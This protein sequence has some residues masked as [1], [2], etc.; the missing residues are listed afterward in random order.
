[1]DIP[2]YWRLKS[3]RYRLEG[4]RCQD[5]GNLSFPPRLVCQKCKSR[6]SEPFEFKGKGKIYSYTTIYQAPDRF[7]SIAPYVVGLIDLEEGERIT[8]MIT[9]TRPE[10]LEIGQEVEMVI[11]KIY[12]DGDRGPVLYGYK[13]RP[14]MKKDMINPA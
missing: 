2:R 1:M 5:C 9:D 14:I 11:R 6:K 12:E 10:D 8:A 13:F 7:D 3:Q 4:K